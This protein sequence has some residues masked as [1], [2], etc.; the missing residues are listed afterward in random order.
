[1]FWV[2]GCVKKKP[3]W[4]GG[5]FFGLWEGGVGGE[6]EEIEEVETTTEAVEK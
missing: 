4:K 1:M 6:C 3:R 5:F 2:G